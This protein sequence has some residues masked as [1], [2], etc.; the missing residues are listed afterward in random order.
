MRLIVSEEKQ[1]L[2]AMLNEDKISENDF[3]ILSAAL[4]KKTSAISRLISV[5]INPFQKIA[6]IQA[7]LLGIIILF[8]MSYA[9]LQAKIYYTG[10]MS[11]TSIANIPTPKGSYSFLL[12]IYQNFVCCL[13]LSLAYVVCA[14][15]FRQ[16][17]LRLIDFIG[18]VAVSRMPFLVMTLYL[19]IIQ[20]ITPD[21]A[22]S[23]V[24]QLHSPWL[25]A[26]TNLLSML[27]AAWQLAIYFYALKESSGLT[28]NKLWISAIVSFVV[29]A[30]VSGELTMIFI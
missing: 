11:M 5:V 17:R 7:L 21:F 22:A 1:R 13:S 25:S 26:T 30:A 18:T 15:V 27:F 23:T 10:I 24:V 2:L 28:G 14:L 19:I 3:K 6:G 16:K 20:A 29:A 8:V 12:L 4:A 9:G